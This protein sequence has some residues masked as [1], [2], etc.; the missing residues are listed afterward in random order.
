MSSSGR[1]PATAC[2]YLLTVYS[3][4]RGA[5]S[6]A[7]GRR[8]WY[9]LAVAA[10]ALGMATKEVMASAPLVVLL[11]DRTFLSGAF[12]AAW[13][14]RG[15][16]YGCLAATWLVLAVSVISTGGRAAT[17]GFASG[18]SVGQYALTQLP[19]VV[20]YLRRASGP[21]RSSLTTARF[22]PCR[23]PGPC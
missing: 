4:L 7:P 19:A 12:R 21:T 9:P 23:P 11:D 15:R 17:V 6:G 18:V 1:S 8:L 3:V 14:R 22:S 5:D 20:H 16:L 10:C 2:S 13:R